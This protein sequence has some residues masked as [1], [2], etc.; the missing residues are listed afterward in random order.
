MFCNPPFD[1]GDR[2]P[3]FALNQQPASIQKPPTAQPALR[4][5]KVQEAFKSNGQST[6]LVLSTINYLNKPSCCTAA[7]D[8]RTSSTSFIWTTAIRPHRE[9]ATRHSTLEIAH[10]HSPPSPTSN[11]P[12]SRNRPPP[13]LP[14][15]LERFKTPRTSS[16]SNPSFDPGDRSPP[17]APIANQQPATIPKPPPAQP[18][19][20]SLEVQNAFKSNGQS[21]ELLLSIF[22]PLNKPSCCTAA[23][24]Q[25]CNWREAVKQPRT[26]LIGPANEDSN[27]E[28][29]ACEVAAC[30]SGQ[31]IR[32]WNS[33][34]KEPTKEPTKQPTKPMEKELTEQPTS[35][36]P[37]KHMNQLA[38]PPPTT[39]QPTKQLEAAHK[40]AIEASSF[41]GLTYE[42]FKEANGE[43]AD[44]AAYY[45]AAS[46]ADRS[47]PQ[48]RPRSSKFQGITNEAANKANGEV[49]DGAAYC[50][51]AYEALTEQLTT[52]Q[53]TKQLEA[54]HKAAIE[55]SSFQGLINEAFKEANGELSRSNQRSSQ[56]ANGGAADGAACHQAAYEADRSSPQS[57]HLSC[58]G[59]INEAANEAN[60]EAD[61]AAYKVTHEAHDAAAYNAGC[62]CDRLQGAAEALAGLQEAAGAVMCCK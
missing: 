62:M 3:P 7:L 36:E 35:K 18:A 8:S 24:D 37:M 19:F 51:A 43:V 38:K 52:K 31:Q 39:K 4:S 42:A 30:E 33:L 10:H 1:P 13:S 56:E 48:S 58:H 59:P 32:Q 15:D 41:Q 46:E 34:R 40:A 49:A 21:T 27:G 28:E 9:P 25:I 2:S 14:F 26:Q 45:Q 5:P 60:G 29:A 61:A 12:P 17:F 53:P 55:A 6:E 22:K 11:P 16:T 47:S 44:G 54:A 20:R 50:Q 57:R 23:F